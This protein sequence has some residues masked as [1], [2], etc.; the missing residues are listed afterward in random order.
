MRHHA[1]RLSVAYWSRGPRTKAKPRPEAAHKALKMAARTVDDIAD[2]SLP[3]E[4]RKT[5]KRRLIR[6]PGEFRG[7]RADQ[8]K[9]KS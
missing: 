9:S 5:R 3:G 7:L 4:E 6:G 1:R 2:K 8:P